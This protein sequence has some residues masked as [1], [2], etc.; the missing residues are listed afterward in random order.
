MTSSVSG[1]IRAVKEGEYIIG[2]TSGTNKEGEPL[3]LG[4]MW[5]LSLIPGQEGQVLWSYTYTPPFDVAP[6]EAYGS[7]YRGLVFGPALAPEDGVF[8]F[9]NSLTREIW[10]YDLATGDMLWGPTNPEPDFQYYGL[11]NYVYEG[12][13]LTFGYSGV[14]TAYDIKTGDVLWTYTAENVGYESPP[15]CGCRHRLRD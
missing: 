15:K 14:L 11:Y 7:M 6:A 2:G 10:G 8:Y 9:V 12:K 13:L 3:E 1:S 4:N 5:A